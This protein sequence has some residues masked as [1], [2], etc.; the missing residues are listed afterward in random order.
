MSRLIVTTIS[1]EIWKPV[2]GYEGYYEVSSFG[3]VKSL[4]RISHL[5]G[6]SGTYIKKEKFMKIH[7][8]R[9]YGYKQLELHTNSKGKTWK[10]H[11][12][13]GL[14]FIPNPLNLPQLNHIDGDKTNNRVENLEW[15]DNSYNQIH[16]FR[17][18]L[19]I[20]RK[21]ENHHNSKLTNFQASEIRKKR[22]NNIS[23]LNLSIEYGICKNSI[24]RI[25]NNLAYN[26]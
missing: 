8:D 18:G 1:D 3:R 21:G 14:A 13:V 10:I 15:C 4:P 9:R 17:M 20:S 24:K 25:I 12:L 2:L 19:N 7:K 5:P 26:E 16:A 23:V 6:N 11:R 22:K